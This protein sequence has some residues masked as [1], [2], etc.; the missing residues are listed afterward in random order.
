MVVRADSPLI[1]PDHQEDRN[2]PFV[3]RP[4]GFFFEAVEPAEDDLQSCF[5]SEAARLQVDDAV[6]DL[7]LPGCEH[8][9]NV[10]SVRVVKRGAVAA[11]PVGR[12]HQFLLEEAGNVATGV[13][14]G[15]VGDPKLP[16]VLQQPIAREAVPD[17]E[18]IVLCL[19]REVQPAVLTDAEQS[20]PRDWG[21]PGPARVLETAGARAARAPAQRGCHLRTHQGK[22]LIDPPG[23]CER[24]EVYL[25]PC[26][27]LRLC[28]SLAVQESARR[29]GSLGVFGSQQIGK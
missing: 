6:D 9:A 29:A 17:G 19:G 21:R 23:E 24:V 26:Q 11:K 13:V 12:R 1:V 7:G 10:G 5:N 18:M 22:Q 8:T 4:L 28:C 25:F 27:G 14:M 2:P 20:Q 16:C 3:R 15:A